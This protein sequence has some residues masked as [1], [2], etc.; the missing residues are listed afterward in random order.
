MNTSNTNQRT[1]V[2]ITFKA[3]PG[4]RNALAQHLLEAARSY[5]PEQGTDLFLISESPVDPDA[6]I[7]YES[8]A[9]DAAKIAHE[10]ASGYGEIRAK[11]GIFLAGPPQV[12]PISPLGGKGL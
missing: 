1:G 12:T 9:S 5:A 10:T 8:Y 7:V 6:V 11:T 2:V 3:K 4:Q